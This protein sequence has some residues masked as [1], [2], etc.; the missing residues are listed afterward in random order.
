M[1]HDMQ[2]NPKKTRMTLKQGMNGQVIMNQD[3]KIS[4]LHFEVT[5]PR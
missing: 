1:E 4:G 3:T 5:S 2:K